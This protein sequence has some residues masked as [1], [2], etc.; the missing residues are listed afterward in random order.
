[1]SVRIP[2]LVLAACTGEPEDSG[3]GPP[4]TEVVIERCD[5]G[6]DDD[7]N[8]AVDCADPA[9]SWLC[10]EDCGNGRDDDGDQAIDC[11]DPECAGTC[12]G[13]GDG[14]PDDL[15]C[16]DTNEAIYP[17]ATE[18]YH[19]GLDNDCDP[20]TVDDDE[21]GDGF[22]P[23][24]DCNDTNPNTWPGA[25]EVCGDGEVNDCLTPIPLDP[26]ACY[27]VRSLGTADYRLFGV[28][29]E[30][31]VGAAVA[32]VGDTEGDGA[33][34][35]L[36]GA[37]GQ[38]GT[39]GAAYLVHGPLPGRAID[40]RPTACEVNGTAGGDR[41]GAWVG[42]VG[43]LN[44]DLHPDAA[45]GAPG[46]DLP[47]VDSGRIYLLVEP[48]ET[49]PIGNQAV[50]V[51]GEP[52]DGLGT[53]FTGAA[54]LT[55]E[56][57]D[58]LVA[59]T[60]LRGGRGAVLVFA[61]P[62]SVAASTPGAWAEITGA[63]PEDL[64]GSSVVLPGDLDGD[65]AADLLVGAPGSG[66][67]A[68][69]TDVSPGTSS[70][71]DATWQLALGAAGDGFGQVLGKVG[72]LSGDGTADVAIAAPGAGAGTVY[73]VDDPASGAAAATLT[74]SADG[75]GF[76]ISIAGLR[77]I[78]GD[79]FPDVLIGSPGHDA[80][81]TDAGA[82]W[83]YFGPLAGALSTGDADVGLLG[84][85]PSDGA[86]TSVSSAADMDLDGQEDVFVGA[87]HHDSYGPGT[88]IGYL[89]TFGW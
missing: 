85:A 1:M 10:P 50:I 26:R 81:G 34:D 5:N 54:D 68:G 73:L 88:G 29:P 30:G 43:D 16:D 22:A 83:L 39:A 17:G 69:F 4:P 86:G 48:C 64:A 24:D 53:V 7:G 37:T 75:D 42:P 45:V 52:E 38:D 47:G 18:I 87:P 79:L 13:D 14:T 63:V 11:T 58:D 6:L 33:N 74:G 40:L 70:I 82:A 28:V 59:G 67:V 62:V 57:Y 20:L 49:G 66:R 23:P 12:D 72:D 76:G 27:G 71:D 15:D 60:P 25:V 51:T 3:S 44:G 65:G 32:G 84:E 46:Q 78:D 89:V 8:G 77:D 61:G 55:G 56:G 19:D 80:N 31:G 36:I 9:C 35:L 21:D 2:L 41:A